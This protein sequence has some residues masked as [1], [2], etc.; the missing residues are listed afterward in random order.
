MTDPDR[1][2]YPAEI[3][4]FAPNMQTV[5][6]IKTT[7]RRW[8]AELGVYKG[9]TTLEIVKYLHDE[10]WRN[11]ATMW[12][13]DYEDRLQGVR[14]YLAEHGFTDETCPVIHYYPS[15]YKLLDSYNWQLAELIRLYPFG[16]PFDYVFIDGAHTWAVD[17]LAFLLVD[18]L[19]IPGGYVD[20]DDHDWTLGGSPTLNPE[21]HPLTGKLYTVEQ[22]QASQVQMIIDL[23]VKRDPRYK[24]VVPNKIYQKVGG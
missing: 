17:A 15:S 19:L 11:S 13:F 4:S 1:S 20:F 14:Q 10:G 12:L 16:G 21:A 22:I 8:I 18:R 3:H 24:E 23:L 6:F 5:E 7:N 9:A 2:N